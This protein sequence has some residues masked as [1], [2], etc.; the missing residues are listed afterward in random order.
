MQRQ[1]IQC[2][3]HRIERQNRIGGLILP[4]FKTSYKATIIKTVWGT[5]RE[6][7]QIDQWNLTESPEIDSHKHS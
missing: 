4:D 5:D 2:S 1:K 3:Q 7:R 6:K